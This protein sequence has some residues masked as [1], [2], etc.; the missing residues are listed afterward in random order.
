MTSDIQ[1]KQISNGFKFLLNGE[2]VEVSHLR[3]N[4]LS[5]E[6]SIVS[7]CKTENCHIVGP[8]EAGFIIKYLKETGQENLI[9][10]EIVM[11]GQRLVEEL[12]L[13]TEKTGVYKGKYKISSKHR[14]CGGKEPMS[15]IELGKMCV[16]IVD[17]K[18]HS[19]WFKI[20][21]SK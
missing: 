15:L 21:K 2:E 14:S 16:D 20:L 7:L 17:N 13:E 9:D 8:F 11:L 19:E 5:P 1:I 18:S 3:Y 6:N 4:E 10:I 12:G